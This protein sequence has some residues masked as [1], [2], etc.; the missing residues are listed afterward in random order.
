MRFHPHLHGCLADGLFAPDGIF[1]PFA[2]IDQAKLTERFGERVLAALQKHELIT[3]EVV[4]QIL[5]QEHSG[6]SVWL[7]D[8]FQDKDSKQFVARYIERGPVALD[9]ITIYDDTTATD[10]V[11]YT[12]NDGVAHEF[13]A[14]EFLALLS[15]HVTKPYESVTRY[16]GGWSC[17]ARG[18]RA[19]R[20]PSPVVPLEPQVPEETPDRASSSWAACI[21]RVYEINP[22]ECPKC[23]NTMRI[24]AFIHDPHEIKKIMKSLDL[25]GYQQPAP[26][27]IGPPAL[28][29]MQIHDL[30]YI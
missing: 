3:D 1:I 16:Y 17:R 8:T 26:M 22:L 13:D 2:A 15:T 20:E 18:E 5:S 6:F 14:L 7:G 30:E 9:K 4:A 19:K 12:T 21:K 24:I 10:T 28:D 25:P 27:T 23:K 29:E 11:T